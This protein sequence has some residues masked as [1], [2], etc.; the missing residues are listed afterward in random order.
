[1]LVSQKGRGAHSLGVSR[2][3]FT[4]ERG[5]SR[6]VRRMQSG[7]TERGRSLEHQ[8]QIQLWLRMPASGLLP[9]M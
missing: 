2:E 8:R 5:V 4:W 3:G 9:V 6:A 1:M 7:E